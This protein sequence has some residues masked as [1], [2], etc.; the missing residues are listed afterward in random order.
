MPLNQQIEGGNGKGQPGLQVVD[1]PM[2]HLLHV[3]DQRQ[4]GIHRFD[5]HAVV[6]GVA[7]TDLEVGR[8]ACV[9]MESG[10]PQNQH[11]ILK[12][13]NQGLEQHIVHMGRRAQPTDNAPHV[14][15][16]QAQL[17]ADDPAVVGEA[18]AANLARTAPF[19]NGVNQL[20]TITVD[21]PQQGGLGQKPPSPPPVGHEQPEQPS[22][23][24][25]PRKQGVIVSA[26]PAIEGP[27]TDPFQRVQHPQGHH[28]AGPQLGL[29]MFGEGAHLV[30]DPAKQVCDKV[31]RGHG[32]SPFSVNLG[33]LYRLTWRQSWPL[34]LS[35][36][37]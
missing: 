20:D 22:A 15:D 5:Q 34:Q 13:L 6:P 18:L 28:L 19:P 14:I 12:D 17:I 36:K 7:R 23:F 9:G 25:Q 1:H 2:H 10:V 11:S 29:G 32:R 8:I 16:Q 30:I 33:T 24:G 31:N 37:N 27:V 21:H 4:H 3:T 26:Q 35:L